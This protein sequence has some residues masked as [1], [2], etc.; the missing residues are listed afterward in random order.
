MR[1]TATAAA[2]ESEASAVAPIIALVGR[3]N[4]GKSTF[5]ARASGRFAESANGPGTTVGAEARRVS[6]AAGPAILVDLP[7]TLALDDR[8][9][10]EAPFWQVLLDAAP[11]AILVVADAGNLSRHLPLALA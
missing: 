10:G 7:G 8:P 6:T 11:D 2:A 4:V 1:A 9:A 5:F 3:P